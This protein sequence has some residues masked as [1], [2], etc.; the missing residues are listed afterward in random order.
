MKQV[1]NNRGG[2][3][4][5]RGGLTHAG[6]PLIEVI[7]NNMTE[8]LHSGHLLILNPAGKIHLSLGK[9]NF[10]IYPRSAIKAIQ[11]SAMMR[12]GLNIA[13]ELLALVS[14]SHI[15]SPMHQQ[16]VK[17]ILATVGLDETAL[18]NTPFPPMYNGAAKATS[19]AAPCSGKHAGM[20]VTSK[21]NR[22]SLK[23]YK[24]PA[25]PMQLACKAELELLSGEKITK[26]AV[27]GCGLP[28]FALTL[29]G[30]ANAIRHLMI[31]PDPIHQRIVN[32]CMTY[33]HMVSGE[34]TLPTVAMQ[35][36]PNLF[37]KNGAEAVLVAGLPDGT[38]IVWKISDGSDRGEN[39]LLAA[40]LKE[41]GINVDFHLRTEKDV[42]LRATL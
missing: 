18:Q 36:V 15:G 3:T 40:T 31:S 17:A 8:S 34:G 35:T 23:T 38:T 42:E 6:E 11:A 37:V 29:R 1:R 28:L 14:S 32:A 26:I 9:T 5:A 4:H 10:L 21:L 25:H 22:W 41:I 19:L 12:H 20:I 16:K 39:K 13:D 30:L 24:D 33:P 2:L 7:R 27:D